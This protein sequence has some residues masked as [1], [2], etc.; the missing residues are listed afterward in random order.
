MRYPMRMAIYKP[1][2]EVFEETNCANILILDFYHPELWENIFLLFT[3]PSL[4]YFK[5]Q[6]QQTYALPLERFLDI[7]INV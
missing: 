2:G 7:Q 4:C 6:T 5:R 1:R 3:L